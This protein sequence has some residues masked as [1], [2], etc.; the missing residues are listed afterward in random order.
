MSTR[1]IVG[2]LVALLGLLLTIG[3]FVL[4]GL[5]NVP[6][7]YHGHTSVVAVGVMLML[8]G[9]FMLTGGKAR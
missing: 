8:I 6:E 5:S 7:S 9:F 4:Q 3:H 2:I 1:S